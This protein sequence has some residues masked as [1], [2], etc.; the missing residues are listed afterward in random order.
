MR[1]LFAAVLLLALAGCA[2]AAGAGVPSLPS[3]AR[4]PYQLGLDLDFYWH[5]GMDVPDDIAADAAYARKLGATAVM[6]SFPFYASGDLAGAGPAT[7][8]PLVMQVAIATIRAEGLAV[9]IRPLLN[10][11][12]LGR[13]RV[14]WRPPDVDAW[15]IAYQRFLF[16][17]ARLA[18]LAGF[19]F[20]TELSKFQH[21]ARWTTLHDALLP[22]RP[23]RLYY[24]VNWSDVPHM[25]GAGGAGAKVTVDAYPELRVPV[26]RFT[27]AWRNW[28]A[29]LPRGTVLSEVGIAARAGAQDKPW[30][31]NPPVTRLQPA[32]QVAWFA[33]A[34]RAVVSD[35]LGG[36]YFWNVPVGL[37]LD[38]PPSITTSSQY[39]DS[40][41]TA[42]IGSCFAWLRRH[43]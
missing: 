9:Y 2:P 6:I 16:P 19:Y 12:T 35:R 37:P 38:Q 41:G 34:C 28:A 10:E 31:W 26:S 22:L 11:G 24:A 18:E 1:R 13:S 4:A 42:A 3:V 17:Y 20:G 29:R 30:K 27:A 15:M 8:P 14:A 25:R 32:V 40:P 21:N 33:A 39:I 23:G 36:I 7:P 5:P 43:R